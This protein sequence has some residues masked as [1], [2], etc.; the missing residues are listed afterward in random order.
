[1]VRVLCVLLL[2]VCGFMGEVL[3]WEVAP[4]QANLRTSRTR[5][6]GL[7]IRTDGSGDNFGGFGYV[8]F[9]DDTSEICVR[10]H[11][12]GPVVLEGR[13]ATA[14]SYIAYYNGNGNP[15]PLFAILMAARAGNL[16][17]TAVIDVNDCKIVQLT[18]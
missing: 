3:A 8:R 1:M 6:A 2:G 13:P 16:E 4:E 12:N 17:V 10:T 9:A 5:I 7:T 14:W 18:L 11:R 15:G